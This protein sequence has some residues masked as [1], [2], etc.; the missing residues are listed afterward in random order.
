MSTRSPLRFGRVDCLL[1]RALDGFFLTTWIAL[2]AE[3]AISDCG[4][5]I[6]PWGRR[7]L[8]RRRQTPDQSGFRRRNTSD[9]FDSRQWSSGACWNGRRCDRAFAF[10]ARRY[11]GRVQTSRT[12]TTNS[13]A[14]G[15]PVRLASISRTKGNSPSACRYFSFRLENRR[16][17]CRTKYFAVP[18]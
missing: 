1:Y 3:I 16:A 10:A 5:D 17:R 2:M 9:C 7:G 8:P 11:S 18:C 14:F 13:A 15:T 4:S 6:R 12:S